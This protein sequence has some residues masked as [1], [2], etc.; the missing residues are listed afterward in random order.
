MNFYAKQDLI[1]FGTQLLTK[2]NVPEKNARYISELVVK[3]ESTGI[4]THGVALFLYFDNVLGK[5]IDPTAEPKIVKEKGATA[6]IDS[7]KAFGHLAMKLAKELAIKKAKEYGIAMI[8]VKKSFWL[9]SLG[10]HLISLLEQG[11]FAKLWA[12]TSTC[13]DCAP[14]GGIDPKFSTNPV[15]FGFPTKGTKG[16]PVLADFSTATMSMGK[17]SKMAKRGE[18]TVFPSFM[19]KEG[20][21]TNDPSSFLQGGSILFLG[22]EMDGY[23]GYAFSLWCEALTA[24]AGGDCNNP[25][26][27]THQSFNLEVID[28]EAFAGHDY[29]YKEIQRFITHMKNSRV[30]PGF[31][32]IRLPGE[33]GFRC[34]NESEKKGIPLENEMVEKLTSVAKKYSIPFNQIK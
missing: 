22:G 15:A 27:E 32:E 28:P 24:M 18:K 7:N 10:V 9:G 8:G 12:Q 4:S 34:L 20:N 16:I 25:E 3:A 31:S 14:Y 33:G 11:F 30:R 6:L 5:T 17:T 23:K 1:N 29:Y 2:K 13:K 26:A 19:D 21:I